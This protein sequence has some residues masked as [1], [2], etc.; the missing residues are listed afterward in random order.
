MPAQSPPTMKSRRSF[1]NRKLT[2]SSWG[3]T[4]NADSERGLGTCLTWLTTLGI[5]SHN[6]FLTSKMRDSLTF[7]GSNKTL[8]K[9]N[10]MNKNTL[11]IR[12]GRSR[13]GRRRSL[14]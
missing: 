14:R 6:V 13:G 11:N 4:K 12:R 3:W 9:Q 10:V 5:R 7:L 2:L 1:C 8:S